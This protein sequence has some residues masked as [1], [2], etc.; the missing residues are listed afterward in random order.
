MASPDYAP[1]AKQQNGFRLSASSAASPVVSTLPAA[2][3]VASTPVVAPHTA[4]SSTP[5]TA[6]VPQLDGTAAYSNSSAVAP[7]SQPIRPILSAP[8]TASA[9]ASAVQS[10]T[11]SSAAKPSPS[12]TAPSMDYYSQLYASRLQSTQPASSRYTPSPP[13]PPASTAAYTSSFPA[14]RPAFTPVAPPS[15]ASANSSTYPPRPLSNG[16]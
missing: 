1:Y 13:A 12:S 7:A 9:P 3:P 5:F 4:V 2:A 10:Q 14:P 6:A 11:S 15:L 16:R 8:H